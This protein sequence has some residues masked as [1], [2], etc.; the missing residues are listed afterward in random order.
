MREKAIDVMGGQLEVQE[1]EIA[2]MHRAHAMGDGACARVIYSRLRDIDQA[3]RVMDA[4]KANVLP[5]LDEF[6]GF[7]SVSL[8]VDRAT[9]LGVT[10]V[11]FDDRASM[12]RTQEAGERMRD[13]FSR[14]MGVDITET[15]DMEI[16]IHHL[17]VPE[18][19]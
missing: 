5:R 17:R 16:A 11:C 4:W 18:L 13:E 12:E 7:A 10:T 8:M 3:D 15:V 19:V 9:G 6:D 14:A 2:V 1:W